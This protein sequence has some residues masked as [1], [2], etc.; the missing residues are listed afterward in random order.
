MP[1]WILWAVFVVMNRS[2]MWRILVEGWESGPGW[3]WD[4]DAGPL[5]RK[6]VLRAGTRRRGARALGTVGRAEPSPATGRT[7]AARGRPG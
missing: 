6:R 2:G 5:R 4:A 3:E 1:W 7:R